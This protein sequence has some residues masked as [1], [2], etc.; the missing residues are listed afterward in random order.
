MHFPLKRRNKH[1][2]TAKAS[3]T[4]EQRPNGVL[5]R[6]LARDALVG[7]LLKRQTLDEQW[8]Q[9][10]SRPDVKDTDPRDRALARMIATTALR[11]LGVLRAALATCL[12]KPLKG[13]AGAV[14]PILIAGAAELLF[15]ES[16]AHAVVDS[17]VRLAKA[18]DETRPYAAL[19]NGVLRRLEREKET[20]LLPLDTAKLNTP[21]W[22]WK[23]WV[24][25]YGEE[26]T[27]AIAALHAVVPP[28]DLTIRENPGQWA[29]SLSANL[30]GTHSVRLRRSGRIET[31]QGYGEGAW[32]VQDAAAALPAQLLSIAPGMVV[33]DLCA[34][35]GGK[36]AQL[37]NAGAEVHAVDVSA[38]RLKTLDE[39]M[40]RLRFEA[41]VHAIDAT[42]WQPPKP[43]DAILLDAPC[44]A[45]GTIR[46]NPDAA[47]LKRDT[48]IAHLA[49][50][51]SRLLDHAATLLKSGGM[52]IYCTCSLEP[53]EGEEQ[54]AAFLSRNE[55]FMRD[56]I[57][58]SEVPGFE[59]TVTPLGEVRILPV[60]LPHDDPALAGASGFHVARLKKV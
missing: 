30:V 25:V 19:V 39:N 4:S 38:K 6:A 2:V 14:E 41:I 45:T 34:A 59:N 40:A 26:R 16:P 28:L 48:D 46:R 57:K 8:P 44:S 47:W 24:R 22:L 23:R 35:P 12:Q 3:K 21:P 55:G 32:W 36:T 18:H 58:P 53:E 52:L 50:V 42:K 27:R 1:L 31:L 9:V 33:A 54:I 7:V 13:R 37:A 43:L 56:A 29:E 11:Q 17:I 5:P 60:A 20:L 49:R 10:F 51:Q 15:M